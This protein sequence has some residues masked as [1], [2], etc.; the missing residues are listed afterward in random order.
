[1]SVADGAFGR[2]Y[3]LSPLAAFLISSI[4]SMGGVSG[5]F[6]LLPFQMTVLGI[7]SPSV[8]ATNQLYNI[9]AIPGGAYRYY[10][11]DRLLWPLTAMVVS[12]SLPGVFIGALIRLRYLSDARRFMLFA[13]AVLL[14]VG[15]RMLIGLLRVSPKISAESKFYETTR[16]GKRK[17]S[18]L[19]PG[20]T[21]PM[22][23]VTF[24]FSRL[25]YDFQGS[26]YEVSTFAVFALCFVVGIIGGI[27]GIGGGAIIAPFFV[28]V[29]SLPVYTVAGASLLGTFVTSIAGVIVYQAAAPFFPHLQTAPDWCLGLL[30]GAGG[31]A[32]MY[33]GARCQKH[34]PAGPI[35]WMLAFVVLLVSGRFLWTSIIGG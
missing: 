25:A 28:S 4:T 27:Y 17:H 20:A 7:T 8:S 19:P 33:V 24:N 16:R 21:L 32:G 3:Y 14:F 6:L 26:R 30:L 22:Q 11:E 10:R 5:A 1:M 2:G 23:V 31:A 18:S 29:F 9:I 15:G 34:V 13:A 35:K 12:G